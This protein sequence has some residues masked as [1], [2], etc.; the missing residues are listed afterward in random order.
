VIAHNFAVYIRYALMAYFVGSIPF[1]WLV[2]KLFF[3][4]DIRSGGSGNI[5]ATN[6]LRQFGT[7][8]GLG[9][10]ALDIAKGM[11]IGFF[12]KHVF[13]IGDIG[14]PLM[15][16]MVIIGHVLPVT[17]LFKG[18]KGVATAGGVFIALTPIPVLICL[19]VFILVTTLTRYVSLGSIIAATGLFVA[20][21]AYQA[22]RGVFDI[23]MLVFTALVVA[24]IIWK[25][26]Q[27]I[28]R[29]VKGSENKISF[30]KKGAR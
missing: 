20:V 22:I 25:H 18:G 21:L 17:L 11:F 6:A 30:S 19:A 26:R 5:G 3:R 4:K 12:A 13:A 8:T 29:L 24:L 2:G 10:L 16:L 9:V 7:L 14:I 15:G 27:N 28:A 1:G 23:P